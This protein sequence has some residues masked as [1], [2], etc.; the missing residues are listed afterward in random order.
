MSELKGCAHCGGEAI[1]R[2]HT[3]EG[4]YSA[5]CTECLSK[6]AYVGLDAEEAALAWNTRPPAD[7]ALRIAV[8]ALE[9]IEPG[10]GYDRSSEIATEALAK[11][12]E[13][14]K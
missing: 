2:H 10:L 13:L 12:K 9:Q 3:F 7:E 1:L 5:E 6:M 14:G 8:E 11:I 4:T